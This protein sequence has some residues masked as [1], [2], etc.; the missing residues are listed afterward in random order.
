M[1]W[2]GI[3]AI[4]FVIILLC[5]FVIVLKN[6]C[7]SGKQIAQIVPGNDES[8][9]ELKVLKDYQESKDSQPANLRSEEVLK[10]VD[11]E[12]SEDS[13]KDT[14]GDGVEHPHGNDLQRFSADKNA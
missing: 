5:C 13:K 6:L 1:I 9:G 14:D 2:Y 12:G 3:A 8:K 4:L 11:L 7:C 10:I